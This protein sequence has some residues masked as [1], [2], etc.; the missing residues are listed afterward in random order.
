[1]GGVDNGKYFGQQRFLTFC[2]N[3]RLQESTVTNIKNRYHA[4]TKRINQDFWGSDSDEKHNIYVESYGRGTCIYTSDVD[5]VV[6]LP[7]R[8]YTKYNNHSSNGQSALL[9]AVKN[10]LYK[11]Y[12]TSSI[13]A[14]AQVV[15]ISFYDGVKFEV[16]LHLSI[17]MAQ[18]TAIQIPMTVVRGKV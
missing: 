2:T 10:S 13:S 1:M 11:T 5:I 8:E 3:L 17:R 15:D 14:D 16:V 18:A 6:E 9:Q 4:I 12:S 7:W